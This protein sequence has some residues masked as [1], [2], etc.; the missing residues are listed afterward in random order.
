MM[1]QKKRPLFREHA[2]QHYMRRREE[3]ILP[4]IVSPPIFLFV[5]VLFLL[6]LGSGI[7]AWMERIPVYVNGAGIV[8]Q[9][10]H[11]INAQQSE[12]DVLVFVPVYSSDHVRPGIS[13]QAQFASGAHYYDSRVT[14]LEPLVLTPEA[15]QTHYQLSC[16]A[17]QIVTAPSVAVHMK[18]I[19]PAQ[20]HVF[21]GTLLQARI[22]TGT[23]RVLSLMPGFD[24][25]M[26]GS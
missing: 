12:V 19:V 10:S 4:R 3:D 7:I 23:Q 6:V 25:L 17:A 24:R 8:Q 22:Q 15:I 18:V 5:W 14:S 16:S 13:G 26:G 21:S 11:S 20:Y 1:Q 9:N 2:L